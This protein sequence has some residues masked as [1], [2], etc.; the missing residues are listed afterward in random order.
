MPLPHVIILAIVQGLTEFL[1]VSSTAHLYLSSWLLGWQA[2]SLDF[3]ISLHIGTLLAVVIYF[4]PDWIQIIAQGFGGNAG[5]DGELKD[6]RMLLWLLAIGSIPA[7]I[8]GLLLNKYAESTWRNPFVIGAMLV[9][10]GILIWLAERLASHA[11]PLASLNLPDALAV[12][13]GQALAVVPGVSRSGIT[14]SAGLFRGL[15]R[16]A[17]AR[18]SFLLS[19]PTIAGA[20][21]KDLYDT[22]KQSGLHGIVNPVFLTGIAVSAVTGWIV[23][24]WFLHYLRRSSLMP[25]VYYRIIFGLAVLVLAF[26]RRPA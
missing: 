19:T 11:R 22:Y 7:G 21:A 26:F 3:D 5:F 18:F 6:N 1:P 17:A 23:I 8:A 10:V 14:I 25:F 16:E 20:A 24:A 13:V 2:E 12:G 9:G 15:T 4:L